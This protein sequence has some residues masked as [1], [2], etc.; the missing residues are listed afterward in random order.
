MTQTD[1][2]KSESELNF[3]EDYVISWEKKHKRL[4]DGRLLEALEMA[5]SKNT[6]AINKWCGYSV[7]ANAQKKRKLNQLLN[8]TK[9]KCL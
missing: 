8:L 1:I 3:W 2:E 9:R 4:A 5:R 7:T 6:H